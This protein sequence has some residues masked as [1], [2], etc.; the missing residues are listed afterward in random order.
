M[1]EKTKLT[2]SPLKKAFE[3]QKQLK[4]KE[5]TKTLEPL[6]ISN[7]INGLNKFGDIFPD[8]QLTNLTKT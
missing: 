2:D 1:I 7:K 8:D 3:K 5:K 6:N 4:I